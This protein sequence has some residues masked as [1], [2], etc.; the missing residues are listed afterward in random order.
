MAFTATWAKTALSNIGSTIAGVF[1]AVN[2]P[3]A[4]LG[5]QNPDKATR[6][7]QVRTKSFKFTT[8]T[9]NNVTEVPIW[10]PDVPVTIL[11]AKVTNDAAFTGTS[12]ALTLG[13][14]DG[15]S[16]TTV[17]TAASLAATAGTAMVPRALTM[18]TGADVQ[19]AS[20][21][22]VTFKAASGA[23]GA[24]TNLLLDITYRED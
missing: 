3:T 19:A 24:A 10:A 16:G 11:S 22:V 15:A 18:G 14:R 12:P 9:D 1:G 21:N 13:V 2:Q 20:P 17:N 8:G 7:A 23:S 4:A 5:N 6:V